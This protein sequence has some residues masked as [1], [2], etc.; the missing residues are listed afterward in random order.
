LL[1]ETTTVH[2]TIMYWIVLEIYDNNNQQFI[3]I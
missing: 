1:N 3:S 2:K